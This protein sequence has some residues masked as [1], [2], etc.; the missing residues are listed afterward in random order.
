[1]SAV[2]KR[3]DAGGPLPPKG[4]A[5]LRIFDPAEEAPA[6][7]ELVAAPLSPAERVEH[8]A[9]EE[10]LTQFDQ[11]RCPACRHFLVATWRGWL[12]GCPRGTFAGGA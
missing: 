1:M 8:A 4:V 6:V 5:D 3:A 10:G 12:C 7:E 11:A 9:V 2:R